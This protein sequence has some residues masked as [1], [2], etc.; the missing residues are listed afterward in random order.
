MSYYPLQ[1]VQAPP[2][3]WGMINV[4]SVAP[5]WATAAKELVP[6]RCCGPCIPHW[7]KTF[8]REE[9]GLGQDGLL[10]PESAPSGVLRS[11]AHP[12]PGSS[13]PKLPEPI[14]HSFH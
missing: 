1:P 4:V 8:L 9:M 5:I 12:V 7:A 10:G 3:I 13:P 2:R 11:P 6:Q 14:Q